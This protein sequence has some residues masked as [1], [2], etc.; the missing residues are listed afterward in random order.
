MGNLIVFLLN[1]YFFFVFFFFGAQLA[2]VIDNFDALL[3]AQ[4]RKIRES[5]KTAS[6]Y[7]GLKAKVFNHI[8]GKLEKYL[9]NYAKGEIIFSK[10]DE[11]REIYYLLEGEVEVL[12]PSAGNTGTTVA[13]LI[14]SS[15]FGEMGHLLS[16]DRSATVKA[17][18]DIAVLAL[19]PKLFDKMLKYDLGFDRAILEQLSQRL[20]DSN[21]RISALTKPD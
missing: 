18:T 11:R 16:E 8:E 1:V 10:G 17:K 15:F 9:C 2:F 20:K 13:Y 19:P 7:S 21:E 12:I 6:S 5:E 14:T 3:F 4:F